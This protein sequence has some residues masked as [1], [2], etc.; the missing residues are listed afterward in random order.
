MCLLF[1]RKNVSDFLANPTFHSWLLQHHSDLP[2]YRV[3]LE[4][5]EAILGIQLGKFNW[6][7]FSF[8]VMEY[9]TV[10]HNSMI[11]GCLV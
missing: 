7:T 8:D 4:G 10:V 9:I 1:Y 2:S 3:M 6:D 5:L 11:A